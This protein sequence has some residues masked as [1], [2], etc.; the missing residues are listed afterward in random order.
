MLL[1]KIVFHDT[2]VSVHS[3]KPPPL[4]GGGL[5]L[6]KIRSRGG[7]VQKFLLERG[8]KPEKGGGVM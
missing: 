5:D 4:L 3:W 2:V 1:D 8:D 6:P 7:G